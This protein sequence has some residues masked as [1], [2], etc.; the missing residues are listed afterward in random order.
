VAESTHD[1][2]FSCPVHEPGSFLPDQDSDRF[3]RKHMH[4]ELEALGR[5]HYRER[6]GPL[7]LGEPALPQ[8]Q[9]VGDSSAER[10]DL[11]L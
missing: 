1:R 4:L 9:V 10:S 2:N 3:D 6:R 7:A 8:R 11:P 5:Q